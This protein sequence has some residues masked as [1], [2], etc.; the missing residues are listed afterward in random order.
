MKK[1]ELSGRCKEDFEK[2]FRLSD[3][4]S[5][6]MFDGITDPYEYFNRAHL[7]MQHGVY[8]DFFD[9]LGI[10]CEIICMSDGWQSEVWIRNDDRVSMEYCEHLE[11]G[12]RHEAR[13]KAIEKANELYNE[14]K[15]K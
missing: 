10:Y 11:N 3:F 5:E 4:Y 2:W 13:Q 15:T 8:E 12:T 1:I 7:S 6:F 9:S 14:M